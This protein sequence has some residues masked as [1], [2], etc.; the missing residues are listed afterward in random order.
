MKN[1]FNKL[2]KTVN[3]MLQDETS[4]LSQTVKKLEN[5]FVS[6]PISEEML[7][8]TLKK[9]E[10]KEVTNLELKLTEE[11]IVIS[12]IAKKLLMNI[13]FSIELKPLHSIKRQISFEVITIKPLNHDWIKQIILNKP[14]FLMYEKGIVTMDL[15]Q[16]EKI[17]TV[18]VGS[19]KA[20]E[21]KEGKLWV[22][23]GV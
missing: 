22:S 16:I 11:T 9:Q 12:G 1:L 8:L 21:V 23:V 13:Q 18:P 7:L 20:F 6:I 17:K 10:L 4:L 2:N 3:D 19:I 14:P 5:K 15:N